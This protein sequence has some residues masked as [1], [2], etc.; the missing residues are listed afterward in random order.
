M[1]FSAALATCMLGIA[2]TPLPNAVLSEVNRS[3]IKSCVANAVMG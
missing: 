3:Q 2:E 1:A